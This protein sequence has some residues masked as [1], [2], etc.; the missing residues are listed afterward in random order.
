MQAR[1]KRPLPTIMGMLESDPDLHIFLG[2][3]QAIGD[4]GPWDRPDLDK[5]HAATT[6]P[7]EGVAQENMILFA[8]TN[9]AFQVWDENHATRPPARPNFHSHLSPGRKSIKPCLLL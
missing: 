9:D 1:R 4:V 3:W 6:R 7:Q 2:Y 5:P 8:P